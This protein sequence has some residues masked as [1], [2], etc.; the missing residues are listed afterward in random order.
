MYFNLSLFCSLVL[1]R[2]LSSAHRKDKDV[3]CAPVVIGGL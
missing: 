3:A 1:I 2:L